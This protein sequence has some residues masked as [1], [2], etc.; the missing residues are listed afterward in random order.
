MTK[1]KEQQLQQSNKLLEELQK[2]LRNRQAQEEKINDLT[3]QIKSIDYDNVE[4]VVVQSFL[5]SK[6]KHIISHLKKKHQMDDYFKGIPSITVA[7]RNSV[8]CI[9][10]TG[11]QIHHDEFKLVLRRIQTLSNVTQSAKDYY[12]RQ[13][14]ATLRS[15]N[16][17]MTQKIRS[18]QDWK[19]YIKYFQQLVQN[20]IEEYFE[21]FNEYITQESK[22]MTEQCITDAT[23]QS[24]AQLRKL[25]DRYMQKTSLASELE[26]LKQE[27]FEEFIKQ[28][29]SSQQLKFEKKPSKKSL[30]TLNEFI[31]EV[32]REFKTNKIYIGRD[33]E[34]FEQIPKLLQRIMIYYRCFLLQLPLYESSKEL[35]HKIEK[36]TVITIATSTGS[37]KL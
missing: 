11:V 33:V 31:N 34:Q 30:Q 8:Y 4:S 16:Y 10:V 15:I 21:L 3:K 37:G 20:R 13:L 25:T 12:Q 9:S 17:I 35:L 26:I 22:S 14:N 23:F 19:N 6:L 28:H 36:N 18:S 5:F 7:E 2:Q 32:K 29:I 1:E 24:S 27:T